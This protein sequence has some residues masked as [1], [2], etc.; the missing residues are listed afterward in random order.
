MPEDD[1]D[2]RCGRNPF[3]S[4]SFRDHRKQ[5]APAGHPVRILSPG[6]RTP[7][8]DV[9]PADHDRSVRHR[10]LRADR[11]RPATGGCRCLRR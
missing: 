11:A 9:R 5:T 3:H 10:Q 8:V 4:N 6:L 7:R 2:L 1:I